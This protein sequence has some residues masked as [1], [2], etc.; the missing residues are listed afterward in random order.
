[1]H[2]CPSDLKSM[3]LA[4]LVLPRFVVSG[5]DIDIVNNLSSTKLF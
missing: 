2:G 3:G 4:E 1:M 5:A